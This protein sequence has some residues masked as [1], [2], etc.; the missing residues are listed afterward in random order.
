[1]PLHTAENPGTT[2]GYVSPSLNEFEKKIH[3][4]WSKEPPNVIE[5]QAHAAEWIRDAA[6]RTAIAA[7]RLVELQGK[8]RE[9]L[10]SFKRRGYSP[11][12]VTTE[13]R[14]LMEEYGLRP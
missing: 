11:L 7:P 10:R 14:S 3:G 1:M 4:A 12:G 8:A 2:L 5:A 13:I 9:L 6:Q